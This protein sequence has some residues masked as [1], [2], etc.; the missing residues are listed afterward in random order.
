MNIAEMSLTKVQVEVAL[1]FIGSNPEMQEYVR[2]LLT[3]TPV[4]MSDSQ[5]A[6]VAGTTH[7]AE[8]HK[9][10]WRLTQFI[11]WSEC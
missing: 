5:L 7:V 9:K 11:F 4:T 1:P 3:E 10:N 2:V 6:G 8:R